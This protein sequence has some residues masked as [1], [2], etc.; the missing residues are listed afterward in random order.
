MFTTWCFSFFAQVHLHRFICTNAF[1]SFPLLFVQT[2]PNPFPFYFMAEYSSAPLATPQGSLDPL[3][4]RASFSMKVTPMRRDHSGT[5]GESPGKS[6]PLC[7]LMFAFS[8]S[9]TAILGISVG[10]LQQF[11]GSEFPAPTQGGYCEYK[12]ATAR[13][14]EPINAWSALAYLLLA[15]WIPSVMVYRLVASGNNN[16]SLLPW[17]TRDSNSITKE[18]EPDYRWSVRSSWVT[19]LVYFAVGVLLWVGSFFYHATFSGIWSY[20]DFSGMMGIAAFPPAYA[21]ARLR[22]PVFKDGVWT[23]EVKNPGLEM[24]RGGLFLGLFVLLY[25]AMWLPRVS[26][27]FEYPDPTTPIFASCLASGIVLEIGY[28]VVYFVYTHPSLRRRLLTHMLWLLAAGACMVAAIPLQ[29]L[30][31]A[32]DPNLCVPTGWFQG[33]A[34]WH[35]LTAVA[36]LFLFVFYD[37]EPAIP[38][39]SDPQKNLD[40]IEICITI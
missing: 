26:L 14:L 7:L 27:A 11:Y 6:P 22:I 10:L 5:L 18:E 33:H 9:V 8:V 39:I 37:T 30:D 2:Q 29:V 40:C 35:I 28:L 1:Q 3:V 20:G 13:V 32:K 12:P 21:L 15:G 25:G 23:G 38:S 36:F 34:L 19:T 17:R 31:Q 4:V 24:Y 16:R